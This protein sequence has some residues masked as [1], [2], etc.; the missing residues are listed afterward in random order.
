[1][2]ETK[3]R[4]ARALRDLM[5]E[6]PLTKVSV[7]EI[8][9]RA[10]LSRK[11]F[12]NHFLDKNDLLN[13]IMY[14]QFVQLQKEQLEGGGWEAFQS[15]LEFFATDRAFFAEALRDMG[16]NSLGQYFS[17]L[18]FEV[19]YATAAK[20]LFRTAG[21]EKWVGLSA[22]VLTEDARKA[23]IVW[24]SEEDDMSARELLD[25]LVST[26]D[27]Y[28]S[29][30]CLDRAA[31]S[32]TQLCDYAIDTLAGSWMPD[33]PRDDLDLPLPTAANPR[34]RD[35]ARILNRCL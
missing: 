2:E 35:F 9:E 11:A 30:I 4:F 33:V 14:S 18:L 21:N 28:C 5:D 12:Y 32:G 6:K 24:L 25:M 26:T 22:A 7:G 3:I 27:A 15:F 19:V 1:M 17:D 8:A 20:G 34:R 29:M 13:W 10:G 31:K 16:Q 23:I